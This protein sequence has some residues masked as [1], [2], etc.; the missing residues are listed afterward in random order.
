MKRNVLFIIFKCV[1]VVVLVS[2]ISPL[3]LAHS[4]SQAN[5]LATCYSEQYD[6]YYIGGEDVGW[7][8]HEDCHTNGTTL[9]Y[10]FSGS[11]ISSSLKTKVND[12]ASKWNS[13]FSIICK[14]D[15]SGLG[16]I[17]AMTNSNTSIVAQ[18][19]GVSD[20]STGHILQWEILINLA[21]QQTAITFA[22]EFGHAIGLADLYSSQN[23]GKLMYGIESRTAT[24][25]TDLD[26]WGAKVI[27][28]VHN[29]HDWDYMYYS[30]TSTGYNRH[31]KYCETCN[32][33]S[34]FV[35]DCNYNTRN[36]CTDCGIPFGIQP[37]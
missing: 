20:S 7:G 28:G 32:G 27:T 35:S 9:T 16:K 24:G 13:D 25:P 6:R 37:W 36:I 5:T 1:F 3:A 14:T 23:T 10:S 21:H 18:F 22:H 34:I 4:S 8:I 19:Q 17:R 29:T 15:G 11:N 26:L 12:G 30:T 2:L 33:K 31:V